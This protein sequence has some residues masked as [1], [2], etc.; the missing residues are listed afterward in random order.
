MYHRYQILHPVLSS[1]GLYIQ[2]PRIG[3]NENN[4]GS[5]ELPALELPGRL[6]LGEQCR[7]EQSIIQARRRS[8]G[9]H[10]PL[11]GS[12]ADSA[13]P[14]FYLESLFC[15]LS[16]SLSL[17]LRINFLTDLVYPEHGGLTT[18]CEPA[19]R[20]PRIFDHF[21]LSVHILLRCEYLFRS[22]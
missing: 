7:F 13:H 3:K 9:H 11:W 17:S 10:S 22:E 5:G 18:N 14:S 15:S 4:R 6:L 1:G 8:R 2:E 12:W 16:L 20:Y 19:L 21:P